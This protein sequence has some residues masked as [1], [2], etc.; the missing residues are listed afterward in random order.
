MKKL[1]IIIPVYNEKN[2]IREI[3]DLIEKVKLDAIEKEIIIVDD[4]SSDGTRDILREMEDKYKIIYQ[5]ENMGKGAALKTG[6][7]QATGDIIIIQDADLEYDPNE[8]SKVISPILQGRADVVYGSRFIGSNPHRVLFFWH[9]LGNK[10][11]TWFSN[12]LN[13]LNLTDMETCYKAFSKQA[14]DEIKN[15]LTAKRFGIEPEMTALIANNRF[16]IYE[17]G[18][19]YYGRT[20]YEGKKINWK[21]GLAAIYHIIKYYIII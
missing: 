2:T 6:F 10:F 15:R 14:L 5:P 20:Y 9:N 19:S 21:D 18:I 11:L 7:L 17:V 4:K 12:L 3:L 8:Y 16:R 13:N 1:S